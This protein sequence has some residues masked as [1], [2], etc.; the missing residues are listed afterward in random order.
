MQAFKYSILHSSMQLISNIVSYFVFNYNLSLISQPSLASVMI[1][2]QQNVQCFSSFRSCCYR[3]PAGLCV[4]QTRPVAGGR[5]HGSL[6][7]LS[8]PCHCISPLQQVDRTE[9]GEYKVLPYLN[10]L[11]YITN[12]KYKLHLTSLFAF[13]NHDIY[14]NLLI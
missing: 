9:A 6:R 8:P 3:P 2:N 14:L 12:I 13:S 4:F 10:I 11:S 7:S 1:S 5:N